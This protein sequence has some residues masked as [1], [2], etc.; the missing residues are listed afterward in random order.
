MLNIQKYTYKEITSDLIDS[1]I[2]DVDKLYQNNHVKPSEPNQTR[3]FLFMEEMPCWSNNWSILK[4]TY[5]RSIGNY[6]GLEFNN[7]KG[8]IYGS[9]AQTFQEY[10][11]EWHV[12]KNSRFSGIMYLTL[13]KDS[14]GEPC[15]TTQFLEADGSSTFLKP[16]IGSW[17]I[18]DSRRPHRTGFWNHA[19]MWSNRYCLVGAS[20]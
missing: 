5:I 13:P 15:F 9:F 18:F 11:T 20:W 16:E 1:C 2:K 17:F 4:E 10:G 8:W 7:H 6:L 12:H 14:Q 3:D 19:E